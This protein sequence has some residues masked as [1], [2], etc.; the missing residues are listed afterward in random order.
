MQTR[1]DIGTHVLLSVSPTASRRKI[2]I[3]CVQKGRQKQVRQMLEKTRSG[4]RR[5]RR[6]RILN[7]QVTDSKQ[8]ATGAGSGLECD[9]RQP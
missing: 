9:G 1:F 2:K 8:E 4:L 7:N 3:Q 6:Q 5:G